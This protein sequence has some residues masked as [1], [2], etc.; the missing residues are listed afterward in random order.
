MEKVLVLAMVFCA[1]N[2]LI[3][4]LP[5]GEPTTNGGSNIKLRMPGIIPQKV[6][7]FHNVNIHFTEK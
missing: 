2:G 3:R 5:V 6:I 4:K 1:C 7:L